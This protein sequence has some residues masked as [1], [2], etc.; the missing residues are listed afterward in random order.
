[1]ELPFGLLP[2]CPPPFAS[3]AASRQEF[4]GLHSG[5]QDNDRGC[6]YEVLPPIHW[7][8]AA[9]IGDPPRARPAGV[10]DAAPNAIVPLLDGE[11]RRPG[12]G[13]RGSGSPVTDRS[14]PQS[15]TRR[16]LRYG[17]AVGW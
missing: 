13:K 16:R 12:E 8:L 15:H 14:E 11:G 9:R 4:S 3:G 1:A 5:D 6:V 10:Y 2:E 7:R 17:R